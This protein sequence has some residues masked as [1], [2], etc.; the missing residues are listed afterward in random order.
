MSPEDARASTRWV[1]AGVVA[2]A[3][4][5]TAGPAVTP[6]ARAVTFSIDS[7]TVSQPD[8]QTTLC[9]SF[10]TQGQAVAGTQNDIVWDGDCA[11]LLEGSCR[12][13]GSHNKQLH[14]ALHRELSFTYRLLLLSLGNV[15]TMPSGQLYCCDFLVHLTEPGT[16]CSVRL[17]NTGASDPAGGALTVRAAGPGELCLASRRGSGL[18]PRSG[19]GLVGQGAA[20]G[21][22]FQPAPSVEES[23]EGV[24]SG[25]VQ[26]R[27]NEVVEGG[28]SE[29]EIQEAG[30]QQAV[31]EIEDLTTEEELTPL[32][33]TAVQSPRG[34]ETP[35][36]EGARPTREA[37]ETGVPTEISTSVPT[38][39]RTT[40]VRDTPTA[41][42]VP[43]AA[44]TAAAATA[45]EPPAEDEGKGWFGCQ[46]GTGGAKLPATLPFAGL[47]LLFMMLLRRKR[48]Q[49]RP[50]RRGRHEAGGGRD[51]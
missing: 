12:V 15:D 36:G 49:T 25:G 35:R 11:T 24:V 32:P 37:G 41:K 45:V 22:G 31:E 33:E 5:C 20:V 29:G 4:L 1:R 50:L 21:G 47:G 10:D 38:A 30:E 6:Q 8:A 2:V 17:T 40:V 39:A 7:A 34:A 27:G 16:C 14:Q 43:T 18:D 44:P 42:L 3:L 28:G 23:G 46:V 19:G 51:A 26:P 13:T 48:T 9:V